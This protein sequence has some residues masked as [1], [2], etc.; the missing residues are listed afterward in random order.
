MRVLITG[1]TG[2]LGRA[3]AAAAIQSGLEIAVL[4]RGGIPGS[5]PNATWIRGSLETPDW[6]AIERWKPDVCVHAAWIATPGVYL[7]SPENERWVE[8][9]LLFFQHLSK[10]GLRQAVVLGTCIEYAVTG[11]PLNEDS[12]PIHPLSSYARSKHLLHLRLRPIL[13]ESGCSL[14]WGRVFYPYGPGEHPARLIS[15]L[16]RQLRA[17]EPVHLKTPNSIK[18]YIHS[19]D[20]ARALLHLIRPGCDGAVNIGTGVGIRIGEIAR[21]VAF[22]LGRPELVEQGPGA[23]APLDRVVADNRRLRS[24]GWN[25][26]VDLESGLQGMIDRTSG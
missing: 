7:D 5:M 2:F 4:I 6:S 3:L 10:L 14:A 25:P 16:I 19:E 21:R 15:S 8:E 11:Q 24:L 9:S 12:T 20:V 13:S 17:G 26:E 22:L 23:Q 18:D 1:G